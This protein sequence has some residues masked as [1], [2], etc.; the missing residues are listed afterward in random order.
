VVLVT[1]SSLRGDQVSTLSALSGFLSGRCFGS[2]LI[3]PRMNLYRV[4]SLAVLR[5]CSREGHCS[6]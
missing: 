6:I 5:L 1:Y 2:M 3:R 4:L